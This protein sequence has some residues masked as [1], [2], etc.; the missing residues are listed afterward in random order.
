MRRGGRPRCGPLTQSRWRKRGGFAAWAA[1]RLWG[2]ERVL[3]V[4]WDVHHG[5]GTEEH[6]YARADAL[7]VS[8]H[9]VG[10]YPLGG[11]AV[12]R[13]GEGAG[14]GY[15][16]NI[17]LPPGCGRGAYDYAFQ[18]VV[19]PALRAFM[20]DL[21]LVSCGFDAAFLD[22]LGR[23]L[24]T[25]SDFRRYTHWLR[26]AADELCGGRLVLAH[27]GGY[28]AMYV[29]FCGLACVEELAGFDSGVVDPFD[30]DAGSPKWL[31]LQPHQRDAVDLARATLDIALLKTAA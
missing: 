25:A 24:L 28:S 8:L 31:D 3:V 20:P 29:P 2:L 17:P 30:L 1:T 9:Q 27:E 12:D 11:G 18:T 13:V 19:L 26:A 15:N 5:N 21:I 23:M 14:R 16:V 6:L 22:P 4:D 10:L 7:F